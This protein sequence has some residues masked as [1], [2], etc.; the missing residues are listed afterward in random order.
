MGKAKLKQKVEWRRGNNWPPK[1]KRPNADKGGGGEDDDNQGKPG[2]GGKRRSNE[3]KH[4]E[5]VMLVG[6]FAY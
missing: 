1:Y 2:G 4:I 3:K 5:F 6:S